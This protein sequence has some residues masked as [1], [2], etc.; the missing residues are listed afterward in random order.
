M[1]RPR[2]S[3]LFDNSQLFIPRRAVQGLDSLE[4]VCK[5]FALPANASGLSQENRMAMDSA[6]DAAGGYSA[7]YESFQQHAAELGQFPMT[8]FVG[9]GALQQI[10][11][12]GM[13]RAC[14]QTVA[15]DMTR[16]WIKI[17]G[18]ETVDAEKL[19]K[20]KNLIESKYHLRQVFHRAFATTGY[21]GGALIFVKVGLD[22]CSTVK[23][24][25]KATTTH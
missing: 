8:S 5:A 19:D 17:K 3:K 4:K 15:D 12:Q 7:I 16:K 10:A 21:M 14:I 22:D 9:Y 13:I 20:L 18:G 2:K 6:F 23:D 11:Q 24:F 1:P 25:K